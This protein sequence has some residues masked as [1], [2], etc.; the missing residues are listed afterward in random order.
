M[1]K[2]KDLPKITE[3]GKNFNPIITEP[4]PVWY[5]VKTR[6]QPLIKRIMK[7]H[8]TL[9]NLF[10]AISFGAIS[11]FAYDWYQLQKY[12]NRQEKM[13]DRME[14]LI[15][16]GYSFEAAKHITKVE[17][18]EIPADAEYNALMED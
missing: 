11:Y 15:N 10:L 13:Y 1:R 17:F 14:V 8:L 16:E 7:K 9:W 6:K 12:I 4:L 5:P 18:K 3:V 2:I